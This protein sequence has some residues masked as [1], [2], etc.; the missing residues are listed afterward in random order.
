MKK[1]LIIATAL[2]CSMTANAA[3]SETDF[4]NNDYIG[5]WGRLKLVGNQLCSESGEPIQLKGWSTFS[6]NYDEVLNCLNK[7]NFKAMKAWGA[8]C[9]RLACFAEN[10]KGRYNSSKDEDIQTYIKWATELNMYVLLDWHVLEGDGGSGD[11]KRYTKDAKGFFERNGKWAKENVKGNVLYEICN[12]PCKKT[13]SYL[14][15]YAE[16]VLP[17]IESVDPGAIVICPTRDWDQ[18]PDEAAMSPIDKSKYDLGLMY[19]AHVSTCSHMDDVVP[20]IVT[21]AASIPLFVSQWSPDRFDGEGILCTDEGIR[22]L[23]HLKPSGNDGNQLIS[24]CFW[25]WGEKKN[26]DLSCIK[27]CSSEFDSNNLYPI[28]KYI[29]DVMKGESE[30]PDIEQAVAYKVQDIPMAD[31]DYGILNVAFFDKG[32]EG[33]AYHDKNSSMYVDPETRFE[34]KTGKDAMETEAQYCNKGAIYADLND[35]TKSFRFDECFDVDNAMAGLAGNF[36]YPGDGYGTLGKDL[37]NITSTEPGEWAVYTINVKKKGYYK[38]HCLTNSWTSSNGSIGFQ[39][40]GGKKPSQNG[41][42]IRSWEKHNEENAGVWNSFVLT[43]TPKCGLYVDGTQ[44]DKA[45]KVNY[46]EYYYCWGWTACGGEQAE[47][48]TVLFKYEGEQKLKLLISPDVNA[49]PKDFSNFMFTFVDDSIPEFE[50]GNVDIDGN[51]D[52]VESNMNLVGVYPNPTENELTVTTGGAANVS[53]FNVVGSMVYNQDV[54]GD[55]VVNHNFPTGIYTVRVSNANGVK[56][57]K[58]VVK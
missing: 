33:I 48:L 9:I 5:E 18:Y 43:P 16:S 1:S 41:N 45:K 34:I 28:G 52:N 44:E 51:L 13:F 26:Y 20:R 49:S 58:L 8:N 2:C 47:D 35:K 7:D 10:S 57:I 31:N 4:V 25:T 30:I 14:K 38:V 3:L 56:C 17:T 23:G 55:V 12:E 53:I 19:S 37:H 46:N 24:W 42:I 22:F 15:E 11:P 54:K 21:A 36:G 6:I 40:I 29:V 39:I 50:Y 27:N 32:G